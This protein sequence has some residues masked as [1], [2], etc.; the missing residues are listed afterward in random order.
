MQSTLHLLVNVCLQVSDANLLEYDLGTV[1]QTLFKA[2]QT[3]EN[4]SVCDKGLM[5]F[6]GGVPKIGSFKENLKPQKLTIG[7]SVYFVLLVFSFLNCSTAS[8]SVLDML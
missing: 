6:F 2:K 4:A 3:L 1:I 7:R 5:G 8:N